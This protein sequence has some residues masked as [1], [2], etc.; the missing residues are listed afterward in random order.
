[1]TYVY[2]P[3]PS[4]VESMIEVKLREKLRQG[5]MHLIGRPSSN[6]DK[7]CD[8]LRLSPTGLARLRRRTLSITDYLRILEAL[9]ANVSFVVDVD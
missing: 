3:H 5:V 6:D 2:K 1:M 8:K 9:E 4:E 7:I